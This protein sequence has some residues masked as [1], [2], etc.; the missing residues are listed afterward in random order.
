MLYNFNDK[1]FINTE[2]IMH[3]L[4]DRD[5]FNDYFVTMDDG[6]FFWI[7]KE[8]F[9]KLCCLADFNKNNFFERYRFGESD[10]DYSSH[11]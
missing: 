11:E 3:V 1:I 10:T 8:E 5:G 6:M 7:T 4:A 9:N 2:K